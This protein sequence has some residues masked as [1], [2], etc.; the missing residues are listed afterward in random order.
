MLN[1]QRA[2]E[3]DSADLAALGDIGDTGSHPRVGE[4]RR[5]SRFERRV[6]LIAICNPQGAWA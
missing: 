6:K 5:A 2:L 4:Q 1:G 3:A